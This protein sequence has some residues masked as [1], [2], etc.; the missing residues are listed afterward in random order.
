MTEQPDLG[1]DQTEE[2]PTETADPSIPE[3][4]GDNGL[5]PTTRKFL[6]AGLQGA[7]LGVVASIA[8][9]LR[10]AVHFEETCRWGYGWF[11]NVRW[12]WVDKCYADFTSESMV[13][14][15]L[16][17]LIAGAAISVIW[18]IDR[19]KEIS[20]RITKHTFVGGLTGLAFW[21]ITL[22]PLRAVFAGAIAAALVLLGDIRSATMRMCCPSPEK[23]DTQ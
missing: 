19:Q 18:Q 15:V 16:I 23:D 17:G 9:V 12:Y 14:A 4:S 8:I 6:L 7:I 11:R 3:A 10:F 5:D 20:K 13:I 21:Y 1:L 22:S 2:E